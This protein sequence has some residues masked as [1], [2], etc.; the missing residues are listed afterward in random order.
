MIWIFQRDAFGKKSYWSMCVNLCVCVC[1]AENK[2]EQ[3]HFRSLWASKLFQTINVR[4]HYP[5][6]NGMIFPFL[7]PYLQLCRCDVSISLSLG[8]TVW[9]LRAFNTSISL[10]LW[11]SWDSIVNAKSFNRV[12]NGLYLWTFI[13]TLFYLFL[14]HVFH[15]SFFFLHWWSDVCEVS[16]I[17][18][19]TCRYL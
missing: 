15:F 19:C 2:L 1:V 10:Y 4:N 3:V 13:P 16:L 8:M 9:S 7:T 14:V 11:P 5:P 6:H 17:S 12:H 18:Y